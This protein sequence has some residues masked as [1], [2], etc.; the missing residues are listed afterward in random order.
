MGSGRFSEVQKARDR[1][2]GEIIAVKTIPYKK[3]TSGVPTSI[4]REVSLLKEL[5]HENIVR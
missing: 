5:E 3:V 2:T 4:I 1:V